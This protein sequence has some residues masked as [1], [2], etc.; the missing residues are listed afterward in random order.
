MVDFL[1]LTAGGGGA[2]TVHT[3]SDRHPDNRREAKMETVYNVQGSSP[4]NKT[5]V[6]T[7]PRGPVDGWAGPAIQNSG[8]SGIK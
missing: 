5:S 4:D 6:S 1:S 2:H 7:S 3:L 8:E